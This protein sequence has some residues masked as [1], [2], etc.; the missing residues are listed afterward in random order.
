MVAYC[1]IPLLATVN[2]LAEE[3]ELDG[4]FHVFDLSTFDDICC[5]NS[6]VSSNDR[7]SAFLVSSVDGEPLSDIAG[8]TNAVGTKEDAPDASC[9]E[10]AAGN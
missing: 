10:V 8:K 9:D 7:D 2:R 1:L 3:E 5:P 6:Q 4:K